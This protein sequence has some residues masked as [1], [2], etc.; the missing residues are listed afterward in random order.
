MTCEKKSISEG[1]IEGMYKKALVVK[2]LMLMRKNRI[3]SITSISLTI[4]WI[5]GLIHTCLL[6]HFAL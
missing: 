6:Y 2:L 4:L 1:I 5:I 3:L